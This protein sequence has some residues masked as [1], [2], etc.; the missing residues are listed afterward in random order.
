MLGTI[1]LWRA[2][3]QRSRADRSVVF[4]AFVLL[5][6][7]IAL[8][9]TGALYGDTVA[10]GG[11]R[12]AVLDAPP[13]ERAIVVR[14]SAG[15]K[16]LVALD[17]VVGDRLT[18][19]IS[20]TG[21]AVVLVA[22]SGALTPVGLDGT[23]ARDHLAAFGSYADLGRHATLTAGRW[24]SAGHVPIEAT[25]S[26]GA[27]AAL[28]MEVGDRVELV[29]GPG[30]QP[31]AVELVGVW[32]PKA[33]DAY[34]VGDPLELTGIRTE[35]QSTLRGPFMVALDDLTGG[36][37]GKDLTL[38]WRGIPSTDGLRVDRIGALRAGVEGLK[39]QLRA[40][41]PRGREIAVLT[42]LPAILTDIERAILVS[43]SGVTLLTLQFAVLAGY[44]VLLVAGLLVERRRSE[45]V[46]LR[47]RG[48]TS[49]H[50]VA[51]AFAEAVLLTVPAAIL[52]GLLAVGIV[53]LI[54]TIGP[55]AD[56]GV[57]ATED[58][59]PDT[60]I[61]TALAGLACVVVLTLPSMTMGGTPLGIR[62]S[63]G[64]Q[65]G[66]TIAQR[67]G[68]DLL[69][70]VLAAIALW[71]LRLYGAPL[72]RD[73]RGVL[74]IDPLLVAAPAIGLLAGAVLATRL[75]PRLAE[76]G[77]RLLG[78]RRGLVPP[79]VARQIARRPLRYTRSALLL[80]LAAAL[81]TFAAASAATF[82][83][84]QVDQ[85]AYRAAGDARVVLSD[86][87]DLP[88]W[89]IGP[90]Y[91]SVA[92]V[93]AATPVSV[94][95]MEVGRTVREGRLLA[96]D[97]NA[98]A[99]MVT[100]PPDS[101][102]ASSLLAGLAAARPTTT[103]VK[104]DGAPRRLGLTIDADLAVDP[105]A[106]GDIEIPADWDAG[107][108]TVIVQDRDGR[109]HRITGGNLAAQGKDQRIEV[110]LAAVADGVTA[111]PAYPLRLVGLELEL[112]APLNAVVT[113][114]V[115][116]K[117]FA[118]SPTDGGDDWTSVEFDPGADGWSWSRMT[119]EGTKP[120]RAPAGSPGRIDI[121]SDDA[122][123][124]MFGSADRAGAT[125]R[126]ESS[127][128][129]GGILPGIAGDRFLALT[130]AKVGDTIAVSSAAQPLTVRIVGSLASFPPLDPGSAFLIVDGATLDLS[131]F[132]A[133]GFPVAASE[134][135]LTVDPAH[136][137][138]VAATL[139][140]AP[141]SAVEVVRR[142]ELSRALAGDPIWLGVVGVL[143][144]GALAAIAFATIGFVVSATVTTDE[145]LGELALLRAL[146]LSQ[147]QL[148][149]W[150]TLE[151]VFLLVVGLLGGSALGLL[152][153]WLVLPYSTL[154]PS[155]AVVVPTPVIVVPWETILPVYAVTMTILIGALISL[156]R[157]V[158]ESRISRVIRAG[159]R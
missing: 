108:L 17:A 112:M 84:S 126:L 60:L 122:S 37:V 83:R 70:V 12:R 82:A 63:L 144:L 21:G 45:T 140:A 143:A 111:T 95:S 48:A 6:S 136:S 55:L 56:S 135:W 115:D 10:L 42:G 57:V 75:I 139:A 31:V 157:Q 52:A 159:D 145:R 131:A 103:A 8:L 152:L 96:L 110:P 98:V 99:G 28:G 22:R 80:V 39:P 142:D 81:G 26:E 24:P 61:V 87:P 74:G 73:A 9:T 107:A 47:S 88:G 69:L 117:G 141:Y 158:P 147:R 119:A 106:T 137:D 121:G 62:A 54:G 40:G 7:A 72:T 93:T 29:R 50:L 86:Y 90:A 49:G 65:V 66:R 124:S 13:A 19:A 89:S 20:A 116:L 35:P 123:H 101:G 78:R 18:E 148:A 134:W 92:G 25:L 46:L 64:R 146:G 156:V 67:L 53:R 1:G 85:A 11:L 34:F 3:V 71:Q 151:Q 51:V 43:R 79:L 32:Q 41:L 102:P 132:S 104:L 68:I 149:T 129:G 155:G 38:E 128:S 105:N 5:V 36:P 118:Q 44:A 91:R 114:S 150:L 2:V 4:A 15:A 138:A 154:S 130:G 59:G 33:D 94:T 100:V 127:P 23:A 58:I 113:G 133:T 77:E 109:L 27:A 153:A 97:P 120:Y 16:D 76:I 14:M 30:G 125:Y